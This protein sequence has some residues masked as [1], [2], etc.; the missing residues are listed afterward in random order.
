MAAGN[1]IRTIRAPGRVV[2]DPTDLTIA[3]PYGGTEVGFTKTCVLQPLSTTFKVRA[4]SLA[5]T[6][7]VTE[8]GN[9]YAFAC[10]ARGSDDDAWAKFFADNHSVGSVSG[11]AMFKV[12]GGNEPGSSALPRSVILLFVP[13]DLIHVPAIL[14]YRGIPEFP[15]GAEIP[16]QRV[17][18]FGLPISVHC[19]RDTN[20]LI[21]AVA[22]FSDLSLTA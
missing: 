14:V 11:H 15:E 20:N 18:E 9:E 7:D 17:E 12:P 3:Y 4:E 19:V 8:P 5:E 16:F 1:V 10:I 13:D 22:R 6:T 21:L 2:A